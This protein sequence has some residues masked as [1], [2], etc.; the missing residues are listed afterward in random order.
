M[1]PDPTLSTEDERLLRE[2]RVAVERSPS[3][4][5][6]IEVGIALS[7]TLGRLRPAVACGGCSTPLEFDGIPALTNARLPTPFRLR[8]DP[9]LPPAPASGT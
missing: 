9:V 1:S 7:I 4:P 5:T 6:Q 2:L 3:R 8:Y